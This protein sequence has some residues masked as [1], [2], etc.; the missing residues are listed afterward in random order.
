MTSVSSS[1][2]SAAKEEDSLSELRDSDSLSI[3]DDAGV[4]SESSGVDSVEAPGVDIKDRSS[5]VRD[6]ASPSLTDTF[7]V[8]REY[9]CVD[10][11]DHA[12]KRSPELDEVDEACRASGIVC[13]VRSQ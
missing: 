2:A 3:S 11:V 12:T 10:S 1:R 5:E 6:S 9:T 7:E 13:Y 4:A 8:S